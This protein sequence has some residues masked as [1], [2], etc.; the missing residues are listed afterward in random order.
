[1]S[2]FYHCD[3]CGACCRSKLVDVYEIDMLREP[4]LASRV[5]PLREPG[6]DGELGYLNTISE[7]GCPFLDDES[8]CSIYPTRPTACVVFEPG[9]EECE[10]CRAEAGISRLEP[11]VES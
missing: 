9:G 3:G 5:M 10:Q 1:M 2:E 7:A 4:R 11:V 6:W 8:C